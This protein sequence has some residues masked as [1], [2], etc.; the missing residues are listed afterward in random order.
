[1]LDGDGIMYYPAAFST[2]SRVVLR[3]LY[4]NA[5]LAADVDAEVFGL[6]AVRVIQEGLVDLVSP[7]LSCGD[8]PPIKIA[9]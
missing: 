2:G 5:I 1:M 6:N 7:R 9:E 3:G 8:A 4:P